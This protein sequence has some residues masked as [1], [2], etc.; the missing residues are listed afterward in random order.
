[1]KKLAFL[2]SLFIVFASQAQKSNDVQLTNRLQEY[3]TLTKELNFEKAMDY[4]HPKLFTIAPRKMLVQAMN[5]AFGNKNMKIRFDS[6]A[7]ASISPVYKYSNALY[8]KV[9]YFTAMTITLSDSTNLK[10]AEL[11]EYMQMSFEAG[12][13]GKKV[14][15][16]TV[17]NAI[18]VAGS[19]IMFAI[20]D[21]TV[22]EWMFLGYDKSKPE[23]STKLYPKSV[24]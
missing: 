2:F 15:V 6:M 21:P 24:R 1:M 11:A 9:V 20:K 4:T 17:A 13:P 12:F 5:Q 8:H 3:I 22:K 14:S 7:I 23:M 16:D 18:K 19:E 10:N